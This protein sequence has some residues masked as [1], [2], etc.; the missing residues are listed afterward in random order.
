MPV[1]TIGTPIPTDTPTI[2]VEFDP[3]HALLPGAH[4][5]QLIVE[6]NDGLRSAAATIDVIVRDEQRPTAVITAPTQVPFGQ[7]F[8]LNGERSSDPFPGKVVRYIW[9]LMS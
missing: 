2:T 4:T 3:T 7:P 8:D 9:T 6:D 5:F 1:F